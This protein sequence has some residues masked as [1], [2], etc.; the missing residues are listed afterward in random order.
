MRLGLC[1]I[2]ADQPIR[3]RNTTVTAARK[4]SPAEHEEK[5]TELI[6]HNATALQQSIDYCA[7]N[8][9]G[10]FRINSQILPV[11][12]HE[13]VG[14][15]LEDL[16]DGA[17]L[18]VRFQACGETAR[19]RG[20]RLTF[21]PD[22]FVVL[23]SPRSDVVERSINEIEYQTRVSEWVGADVINIHGGGAYGD[24]TSALER[25][26][27]TIGRLSA[28]ARSRLTLENDDKTYSPSALLP[29][30]H[31]AGVP[32][33]YDVHHHRCH[34]DELTIE[35]ATERA[36]ETW[37]REPLFHVSSPKDGWDKPRPQR[38]HDY[39]NI[40]DFPDCWRDLDITVEVEAKMKE[41]AVKQLYATLAKGRA[42]SRDQRSQSGAADPAA[43]SSRLPECT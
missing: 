26:R 7:D 34:N 14:Y 4:R 28:G 31:D 25:L 30:C 37:D 27:T 43:S 22:Q 29:V 40:N 10:S 42:P 19:R 24:P 41:Q 36:L 15:R 8:G 35:T 1:C 39:I 16:A 9:I 6:A 2:F 33:V 17:E 20:I 32:L 12:T 5:L 11:Y 3:F 21:H 23:N 18:I 13:D 38:H